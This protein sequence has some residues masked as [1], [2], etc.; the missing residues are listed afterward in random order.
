M[1]ILDIT[2]HI[3]EDLSTE[4]RELFEHILKG[5]QGV[6]EYEQHHEAPHMLIVKFDT[7]KTTCIDII[8]IIKRSGLHTELIG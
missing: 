8:N 5:H 6:V 7:N 2:L 4:Q 1:D 3:D